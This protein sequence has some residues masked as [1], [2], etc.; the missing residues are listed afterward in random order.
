M[1]APCLLGCHGTARQRPVP[2][3]RGSRGLPHNPAGSSIIRHQEAFSNT[4]S[5]G[6][7]IRGFGV[8][9]PGGAP[10]LTWGFY[11]TF[12]LVNSRFR[13]MFAPRLLVSPNLVVGGVSTVAA[14]A[15]ADGR[16]AIQPCGR[17][18]RSAPSDGVTQRETRW[19]TR[20]PGTRQGEA[21]ASGG[22]PWW[23]VL[24]P[25]LLADSVSA[26]SIRGHG[27]RMVPAPAVWA[28][29]AGRQLSRRDG[30]RTWRVPDPS[31]VPPR[32]TCWR[33]RWR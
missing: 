10:V 5:S 8:Q 29:C 28:G 24:T 14:S 13:A 30:R 20:L 15:L 3:G 25:N 27:W 6:L 4:L 33:M 7:L 21:A 9:V 23:W 1:F 22:P 26:D 11:C 19:Y 18:P 2:G 31:K 32:G 12:T 16:L 17:R